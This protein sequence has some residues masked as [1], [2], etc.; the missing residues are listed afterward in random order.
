MFENIE[1]TKPDG[2]QPLKFYYNREER[3]KKASPQVQ[4]YYNGGMRPI[5]GIKALF[6]KGNKFIVIALIFFVAAI[7]IFTGINKTVSYTKIGDI[8]FDVQAFTYERE[9]YTNIK[10][11]NKKADESSV[12]QKIDADVCFINT[13]GEISEGSHLSLVYKNGEE[14]LRTKA[15]D[16]D[17]IKVEVTVT[18][19]EETKKL[20]T[21]VSRL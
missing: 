18:I 8:S 12:P 7:W 17:I 5:K 14:Y 4:E 2:E 1:E 15:I 11:Y 3:L 21:L 20:S 16:Y 9:V 13:D 6:Y 10:V 19:G